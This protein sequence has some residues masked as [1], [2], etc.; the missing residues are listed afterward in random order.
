MLV[1]MEMLATRI[2]TTLITPGQ[3]VTKGNTGPAI[4]A[5]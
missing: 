1:F 4:R 3:H 2:Y 5:G